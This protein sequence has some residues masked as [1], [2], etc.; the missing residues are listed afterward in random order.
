M[1]ITRALLIVNPAARSAAKLSD[2]AVRAFAGVGVTCEV[3]N[4]ERTGHAA[5]IARSFGAGYDAVFTLGGDGTAIE[6][7][8]ALA[9][10]MTPV[11]VLPGGTGNVLA[12]S[13][14]IPMSVSA[15]VRALHSGGE[16][17]YD[18][19]KL[20]DGRHFVIGVGVGV[21][22]EMIAGASTS[23]KQALGPLAYFISGTKAGL[24][25]DRFAYRIT[26]DG[27]VHEGKA[28]SVLVANLGK[29]LGGLITLGTQI[30]H[31]DGVLH[32][33][34]FAPSSV[35]QAITTFGQMLT[36]GAR[37]GGAVTYIAGRSIRI[38]TTPAK[39]CQSDGEMLGTTPIEMIV[40]AGA[41]RLLTPSR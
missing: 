39:L 11:G 14:K 9:G 7:I 28:I 24:K 35:L 27:V 20:S 29:I 23:S 32:V 18:L 31:D 15:A 25:L 16:T 1:T 26:A 6:A 8:G 2:D 38:E 34:V 33:C 22:A 3:R 13:L 12:R 40:V 37:E 19:G 41:A 5:E 4:T 36:G 10:S 21:D 17:R 30:K